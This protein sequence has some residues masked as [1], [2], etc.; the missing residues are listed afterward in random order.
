MPGGPKDALEVA[1][2]WGWCCWCQGAF[3]SVRGFSRRPRHGGE[4][5]PLC[6]PQARASPRGH[7]ALAQPPMPSRDRAQGV[8][9]PAGPLWLQVCNLG[10]SW[11]GGSGGLGAAIAPLWLKLLAPWVGW[12]PW[13]SARSEEEISFTGFNPLPRLPVKAHL[14]PPV[15]HR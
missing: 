12:A 8:G 13:S 3:C 1:R 10:Q 7:P 6:P 11:E 2:G 15:L 4:G 5:R 9:I 14:W